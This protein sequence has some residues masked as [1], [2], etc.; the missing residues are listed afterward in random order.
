VRVAAS[1]IAT[2]PPVNVLNAIRVVHQGADIPDAIKL[3][4]ELE[5][6]LAAESYFSDMGESHPACYELLKADDE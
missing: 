5:A 2:Q 6:A 4:R 3:R 1:T